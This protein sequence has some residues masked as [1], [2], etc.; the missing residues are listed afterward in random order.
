MYQAA[1][2]EHLRFERC[3]RHAGRQ[4]LRHARVLVAE[5]AL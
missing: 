5:T 3:A 2:R 1:L 4:D